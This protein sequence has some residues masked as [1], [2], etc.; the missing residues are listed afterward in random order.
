MRIMR[1]A[2]SGTDLNQRAVILLGQW[3]SVPVAVSV[4]LATYPVTLPSVIVVP[5]WKIA[6]QVHQDPARP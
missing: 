5:P 4:P 6:P 1:V 3:S 2:C